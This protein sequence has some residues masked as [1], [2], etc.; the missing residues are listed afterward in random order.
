MA[1]VCSRC[2]LKSVFLFS[3]C[4]KFTEDEVFVIGKIDINFLENMLLWEPKNE[5]WSIVV[6]KNGLFFF[7]DT[8]CVYCLLKLYELFPIFR[9]LDRIFPRSS[10]CAAVAV[11]SQRNSWSISRLYCLRHE[12]CPCV[13]NLHNSL[14]VPL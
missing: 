12:R 10:P 2:C 1:T 6:I 14:S 13:W 3:S 5:D 8:V 7:L 4:R 9:W 11:S